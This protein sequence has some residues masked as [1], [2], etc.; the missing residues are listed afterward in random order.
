MTP[1]ERLADAGYPLLTAPRPIGLYVPAT[2]SGTLIFT[3]GQ[4]PIHEGSIDPSF[5]GTVG[6]TVSVEQ[7]QQAAAHAVAN[8]VHAIA[9]LVGD[10]E[11]IERIV[12]MTGFVASSANFTDQSEVMNAASILLNHVF[13]DAGKH[14]RSAVGV[15]SLPRGVCVEIELIVQIK[16]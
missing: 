6:T 11:C 10:L 7:A 2:T 9:E 12:K 14:A 8:A 3:S 15:A 5:I 4:I 16:A 13:G 1:T